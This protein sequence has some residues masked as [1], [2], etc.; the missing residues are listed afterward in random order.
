[1]LG[2]YIGA[3][4]A[5]KEMSQNCSAI[6]ASEA[7]AFVSRARSCSCSCKAQDNA[8]RPAMTA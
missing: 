5:V 3:S 6:S 8:W 4:V 7:M 2:V 1:M